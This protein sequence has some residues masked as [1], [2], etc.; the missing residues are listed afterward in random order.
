MLIIPSLT[1]LVWC[2]GA[3]LSNIY[4]SYHS[5]WL[6]GYV[7]IVSVYNAP[8]YDPAG[9]SYS[10]I[11]LHSIWVLLLVATF[12]L[13]RECIIKSPPPMGRRAFFK[14]ILSCVLGFLLC[15]F[16]AIR[17]NGKSFY[18]GSFFYEYEFFFLL[19]VALAWWMAFLVFVAMHA[20]RMLICGVN[21]ND[22]SK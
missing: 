6:P 17:F 9:L 5:G 7:N 11:I 22:N 19:A 21:G 1:L 15:V 2:A 3:L 14:A 16:S 4:G 10:L 18:F 8:F 13:G 20:L 12:F